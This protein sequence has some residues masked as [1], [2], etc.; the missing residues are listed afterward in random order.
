MFF[1]ASLSIVNSDNELDFTTAKGISHAS[2]I[3]L[4]WI[5]NGFHNVRG[6]AGNAIG[7][8]WSSTND[9]FLNQSNSVLSD[10][11]PKTRNRL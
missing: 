6:L 1:Y 3:Y 5:A 11:T 10:K 2:G 7:M 4:G 8:D 9:T